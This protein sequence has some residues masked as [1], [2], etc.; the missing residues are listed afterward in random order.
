MSRQTADNIVLAIFAAIIGGALPGGA[1]VAGYCIAHD[2][3]PSVNTLA[4]NGWK[5][6]D[7][8]GRRLDE[9]ATDGSYWTIADTDSDLDCDPLAVSR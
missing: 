3:T 8:Q 6:L 2:S 7:P 5:I 4:H 9:M 1:F